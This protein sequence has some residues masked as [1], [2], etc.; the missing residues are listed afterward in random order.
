MLSC[1]LW[2]H[3]NPQPSLV[4]FLCISN[5][6]QAVITLR[7]RQNCQHLGD[8]IFKCIFLNENIRISLK[9]SL[10]F[11]SKGRINNILA[12][13]QMM[14]WRRP[15]H[16][17]LSETMMLRLPTYMCVTRPHSVI[18]CFTACHLIRKK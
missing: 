10:K 15:G 12:L 7:P 4:L 13:V 8:V 17:P 11:I 1:P 16:K 5:F 2:C 6:G 18:V 9:I 3:C 14:A